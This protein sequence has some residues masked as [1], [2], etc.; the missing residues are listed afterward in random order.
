LSGR[1]DRAYRSASGSGV[2]R[3]HG[4]GG[5]RQIS[6]TVPFCLNRMHASLV[7]PVM[8]AAGRDGVDEGFRP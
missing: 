6:S 8:V 5:S 4:A 3:H 7:D 1:W 2:F